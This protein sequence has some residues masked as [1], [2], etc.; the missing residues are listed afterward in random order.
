MVRVGREAVSFKTAILWCLALL[1]FFVLMAALG[2]ELPSIESGSAGVVCYKQDSVEV[3]E[4][5]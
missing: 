4:E 5:V 2:T 3:V 1:A